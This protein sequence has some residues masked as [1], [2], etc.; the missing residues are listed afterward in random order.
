MG[1]QDERVVDE[2]VSPCPQ[3]VVIKEG[4]DAG[5]FQVLASGV[6]CFLR[7]VAAYDL[8]IDIMHLPHLLEVIQLAP[9]L[10]VR[11]FLVDGP[12]L[13]GHL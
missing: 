2:L 11:L 7:D 5:M 8:N 12:V 3:Q 6:H 4:L 10:L 9:K 13:E 1:A